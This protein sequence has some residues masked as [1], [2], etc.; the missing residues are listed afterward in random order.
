[1]QQVIDGKRLQNWHR[2]LQTDE[3]SQRYRRQQFALLPED[4]DESRDEAHEEY[5]PCPVCIPPYNW[6]AIVDL[7][8]MIVREIE[9]K[10]SESDILCLEEVLP[11]ELR[12]KL[13]AIQAQALPAQHSLQ[14]NPK[15]ADKLLQRIKTMVDFLNKQEST[16]FKQLPEF[17]S[18]FL[19]NE[20]NIQD[21]KEA[22][23]KIGR[24]K[25][26]ILSELVLL[27]SLWIR[28]LS[29]WAVPAEKENIV[30]SLFSHLFL[31]YPVPEFLLNQVLSG[32]F[33]IERT[34]LKLCICWGQ[35][36][37]L[38]EAAETFDW[39]IWKG[40]Q[41]QLSQVPARL[42]LYEA[43]RYAKFIHLGLK[44]V[45]YEVL[46]EECGFDFDLVQE[47]HNYAQKVKLQEDILRWLDRHWKELEIELLELYTDY[48]WHVVNNLDT[49]PNF[50]I[51]GRSLKKIQEVAWEY[52]D[53]GYKELAVKNWTQKGWES[54]FL[55]K[56]GKA[57]QIQEICNGLGLLREGI[58]M[59]HCVGTYVDACINGNSA[60]FSLI[61]EGRSRITIEV[62]PKNMTIVQAKGKSNREARRE[63]HE[64][65]QKWKEEVLA[66]ALVSVSKKK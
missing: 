33:E 31:A 48:F 15:A 4:L 20:E 22:L 61:H 52:Q 18:E 1:M 3:L 58:A 64:I 17:V 26:K 9:S 16:N 46:V 62:Q 35:G 59:S 63:E 36:I 39:K 40:L 65:I 27:N 44:N 47:E 57:W 6:Y 53:A 50:K 66:P 30:R 23:R 34:P 13:L 41:H 29:T 54:C 60:I 14:P 56:E 55:D 25:I 32:M 10:I 5:C 28:P 43:C 8:S 38:Q 45:D 19:E 42:N 12:A 49:Y 51:K 11:D 24:D 7:Q 37:S 2:P 21:C